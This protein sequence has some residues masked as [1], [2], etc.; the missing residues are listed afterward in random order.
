MRSGQN[1]EPIFAMV[2]GGLATIIRLKSG[3]RAADTLRLSASVN[4]FSRL[5]GY[6]TVNCRAAGP[7]TKPNREAPHKI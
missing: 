2:N 5:H 6:P 4:S 3:E 1:T 7:S